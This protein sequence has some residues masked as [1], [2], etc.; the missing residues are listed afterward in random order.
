MRG[1]ISPGPVFVFESMLAARRWQHYAGRAVFVLAIL[2]GLWIVWS[3][4]ESSNSAVATPTGGSRLW[5]RS[6][7]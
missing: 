1:R 6:K 4:S 3:K 7:S 2:I 5:A